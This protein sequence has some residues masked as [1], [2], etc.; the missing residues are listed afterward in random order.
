[1]ALRNRGRRAIVRADALLQAR[2]TGLSEDDSSSAAATFTL[3]LEH[4]LGEAV[5]LEGADLTQLRLADLPPAYVAAPVK[6]VAF[7]VAENHVAMPS[8]AHRFEARSGGGGGGGG[9]GGL[10][11]LLTGWFGGAGKK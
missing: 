7:D 1:M 4:R 11:G 3:A 5:V 6:P 8:I 10:T 9:G 2:A